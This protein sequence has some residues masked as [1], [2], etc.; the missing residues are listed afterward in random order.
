VEQ[1]PPLLTLPLP[2]IQIDSSGLSPKGLFALGFPPKQ[3]VRFCTLPRLQSL[4]CF[5]VLLTPDWE[6]G[7]TGRLLQSRILINIAMIVPQIE[8]VVL[9]TKMVMLLKAEMKT[10]PS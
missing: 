3:L 6:R 1:F 5:I 9:C 8:T 4:S 7:M 10:V 2:C